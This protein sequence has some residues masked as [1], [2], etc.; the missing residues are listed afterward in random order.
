M[1]A[2]PSVL[3]AA[4]VAFS[5]AAAGGA[6][7]QVGAG[8]SLETDY[9]FRGVSLSGGRPAVHLDLAWDGAGGVYA[10]A[11]ATSVELERG[12]R[13]GQLIG[14][15]GI[16]R[17][18]SGFGWE[19]G[20]TAA[21]F[22]AAAGYDYAELYAGLLGKNWNAR[23]SLSPDYFGHGARTLYAELNA[24]SP[25]GAPWRVFAHLGA[26]GAMGGTA[27]S[28]RPRYDLRAGIAATRDAWELQLAWV[29]AGS[30]DIYP[31]PYPAKR[32]GLVLSVAR[33]F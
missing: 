24:G 31:A 29:E 25:L 1:A 23:L 27:A 12:M 2:R 22:I 20:A 8:L 28:T 33:F 15:L 7:A 19:V 16:A 21:H 10:G 6:A 14:Y 3:R 11:A 17:A 5:L 18:T 4:F 9:R 13:R 26:L 32:S 30:G